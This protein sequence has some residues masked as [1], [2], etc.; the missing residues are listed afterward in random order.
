[1]AVSG[2]GNTKS[3]DITYATPFWWLL[4]RIR[5]GW[6]LNVHLASKHLDTDTDA[7]IISD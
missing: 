7:D 5:T 2:A 6:Y 4:Q 3:S 1:M